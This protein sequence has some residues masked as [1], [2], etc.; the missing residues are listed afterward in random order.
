MQQ[1]DKGMVHVVGTWL[2]WFCDC[3]SCR[4]ALMQRAAW[5]FN[6]VQRQWC[7]WCQLHW[8]ACT[9][10]WR[11]SSKRLSIFDAFLWYSLC[12]TVI[13]DDRFYQKQMPAYMVLQWGV[14]PWHFGIINVGIWS[15]F[16]SRTGWD[17][18]CQQRKRN[19]WL[20]MSNTTLIFYYHR[21]IR[22]IRL[23]VQGACNLFRFVLTQQNNMHTRTLITHQH[24]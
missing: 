18:R 4:S 24:R 22:T 7:S 2:Y 17:G 11:M 6:A 1:Q 23:K 14:P 12:I 8:K 20:V 19:M 21:L 10:L 3:N 5:S 15:E 13:S 9:S 16:R